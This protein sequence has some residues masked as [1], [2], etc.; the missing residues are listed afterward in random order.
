MT[1]VNARTP[2]HTTDA[3]QPKAK[4]TIPTVLFSRVYDGAGKSVR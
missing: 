4:P 2:M 1:K 3:A